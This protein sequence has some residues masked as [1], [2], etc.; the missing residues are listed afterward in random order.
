MKYV[1]LTIYASLENE[2]ME[3]LDK[4]NC[5]NAVAP[6]VIENLVDYALDVLTKKEWKEEGYDV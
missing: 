4:A 5:F 6:I 2:E 3:K 1:K